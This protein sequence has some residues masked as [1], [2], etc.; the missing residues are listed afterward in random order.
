MRLRGSLSRAVVGVSLGVAI[1]AAFALAPLKLVAYGQ[2]A[3]PLPIC[4][5][6]TNLPGCP[7]GTI[8]T[9]PGNLG[10]NIVI[11]L[12]QGQFQAPECTGTSLYPIAALRHFQ[13]T[14]ASS[15]KAVSSPSQPAGS[16]P[17]PV[18]PLA[19][20]VTISV[21]V[22]PG[23]L[24]VAGG[25]TSRLAVV[26]ETGS[27][28]LTWIPTSFDSTASTASFTVKTTGDYLL[29]A[30]APGAER[31]FKGA[32]RVNGSGQYTLETASGNLG[33]LFVSSPSTPLTSGSQV[34]VL[35]VPPIPSCPSVNILLAT[36]V[37]PVKA[38]LPLALPHT[39]DGGLASINQRI[40]K[41][42]LH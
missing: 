39:G 40:G 10:G 20:P 23:L 13:V 2:T 22:A 15:G 32:L 16:I 33:V 31:E 27:G 30:I 28:Q 12:V 42:I 9:P 19:T 35:G 37:V 36:S 24:A 17:V 26:Q 14:L 18:V 7:T 3:G 25:S 8:I 6:G 11:S 29:I 34:T 5:P 1:L 38:V 41:A 4:P 21:P